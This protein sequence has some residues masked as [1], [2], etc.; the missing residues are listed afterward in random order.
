MTPAT[1]C[2]APRLGGEPVAFHLE[3]QPTKI[4]HEPTAKELALKKDRDRWGGDSQTWRTWDLSPSG[5]LALIIEEN[6]YS[7]LRR[8]YSQR[9]GH[10]FEE[11]LDAI[12]MGLA[13]HAALKVE[14]RR[15]A[16]VRANAAAEAEARRQR[17]EAFKHRESRRMAFTQAVADALAERVKL[18]AVL[19]HLDGDADTA[20]HGPVGM[21]AWLHRRLQALEAR[22]SFSALE[23]SARHAEIGFD[24]PPT[25][26][27]G[28]RWYAPE[29]ELHLWIPAEEEGRVSGVSE[30]EW[31]IQEGLITDPGAAAATDDP[32]S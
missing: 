11:S 32:D 13:A 12:L 9:K 3:E 22:L 20:V 1:P 24:E 28:S 21:D 6:D 2:S 25:G 17:L 26:K 4:P 18:R 31:A 23:I 19:E 7:G 10:S 8:T 16:E 30:L 15:E 14:R 27:V 29:V 5:R